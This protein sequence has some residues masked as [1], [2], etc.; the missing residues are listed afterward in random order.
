MPQDRIEQ[1]PASLARKVQHEAAAMRARTMLENINTLPGPKRQ[2]GI[3]ERNRQLRL[4][5]CRADVRRHIIGAFHGVPV[6]FRIFRRQPLEEFIEIA[7]HVR[8][9]VFLN[10][11]RRRGVLNKDSEQAR[12]NAAAFAPRL[13][14]PGDRVEP[15]AAR[16]HLHAM[17]ELL[18]S[19]VTLLARFRG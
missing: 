4:G 18:H 16:R 10:G 12:M 11:Q 3:D 19:T 6:P 1:T 7:N 2:A 17:R 5:K 14:F 9:G 15:F 8:V 13:N